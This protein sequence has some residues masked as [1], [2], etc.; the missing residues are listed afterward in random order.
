MRFQVAAG[1]SSDI[2]QAKLVSSQALAAP[3]RR[4]QP[5]TALEQMH[6]TV[7]D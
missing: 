2:A 5:G 3:T 7:S 4:Q 6:I 1:D